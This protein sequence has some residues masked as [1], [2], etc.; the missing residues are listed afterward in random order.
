MW[1][2]KRL[3]VCPCS[4][5]GS[6][7]MLYSSNPPTIAQW[8]GLSTSTGSLP[9]ARMPTEPLPVFEIYVVV[10]DILSVGVVS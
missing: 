5:S 9:V 3:L 8:L 4:Y 7:E 6:T 10:R 1:C 2:I